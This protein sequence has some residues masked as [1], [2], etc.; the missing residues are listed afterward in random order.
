MMA[1]GI[2]EGSLVYNFPAYQGETVYCFYNT[3]TSEIYC[4]NVGPF[5][6]ANYRYW[7]SGKV[8]FNSATPNT[9]TNFGDIG[10]DPIVYNSAGVIFSSVTLYN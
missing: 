2:L 4:E 7:I 8:F 10:I 5:I 9:L 1:L 3:P 6:N